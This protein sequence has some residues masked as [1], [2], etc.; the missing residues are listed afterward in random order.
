ML[1]DRLPEAGVIA[2]RIQGKLQRL[3]EHLNEH[4]S[5]LS[6]GPESMGHLLDFKLLRL[7]T[8]QPYSELVLRNNLRTLLTVVVCLANE[9]AICASFAEG[10]V[11]DAQADR[12]EDLTKRATELGELYDGSKLWNK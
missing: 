11:N 2:K 9:A 5:H 4:A 3:R 12:V 7:Q 1:E 6:V 8:V 10:R